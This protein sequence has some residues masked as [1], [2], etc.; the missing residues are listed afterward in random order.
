MFFD[1]TRKIFVFTFI[2]VFTVCCIACAKTLLKTENTKKPKAKTSSAETKKPPQPAAADNE[3]YAGE[4]FGVKVPLSNYYFIHNGIIVFGN[5][6]RGRPETEKEIEDLTWEQLLLSFIAFQEN[7]TVSPQEADAEIEKA[8]VGA[9]ASQ[10]LRKDKGAYEA[11]LKEKVNE[12]AEIFENQIKHLIQLDK[13]RKYITEKIEPKI[14]EEEIYQAFL[15]EASVLNIEIVLF[16]T[17]QEAEDFYKKISRNKR[18]WEQEKKKRPVDFKSPGA[19]SV[20]YLV[21]LWAVPQDAANKMMKKNAGEFYPPRPVYKKFAV[22]K[23]LDKRAPDDAQY[24]KSKDSFLEK[25]KIR[26]KFEGY[27]IWLENLKKTAKIVKYPVLSGAISPGPASANGTV[28]NT[29]GF[30]VPQKA[31]K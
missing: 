31:E 18:L 28:T 29:T 3:V 27:N 26:K 8:L 5:K 11:W 6:G 23:I 30:V 21:D 7:I 1:K 4:F 2:L 16:D 25:V 15:N 9:G 22:F 14:S 13:L 24:A 10:D 12:P 19:V 17:E 20:A